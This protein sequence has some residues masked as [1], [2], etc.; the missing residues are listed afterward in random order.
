MERELEKSRITHSCPSSVRLRALQ[1][2][3]QPAA[4][5]G[6]HCWQLD[7]EV[8]VVTG[9]H[10]HGR[11]S[12][13]RHASPCRSRCWRHGAGEVLLEPSPG[14]ASVC[15]RRQPSDADSDPKACM[16]GAASLQ[17]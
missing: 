11:A 5:F 10:A 17:L 12:T 9:E 8:A 16:C 6:L 13:G 4:S 15:S 7:P 14:G 3:A 1:E 2:G